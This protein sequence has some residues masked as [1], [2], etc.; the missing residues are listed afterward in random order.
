MKK[1][2]SR[3]IKES[4]SKPFF[5]EKRALDKDPSYPRISIITPSYNQAR[6]LESTI[7]SVLNQNYPN[8]EY[9]I[10]DG[11]ST[12]GSAD[13]IKKYEKYLAYW[14]SEPDKGQADALNKGFRMATGEIFGWL[15]SDD[16][17]YP[18]TI[19]V[20]VSFFAKNHDVGL[21]Y[22]ARHEIDNN[23]NF[24]RMVKAIPFNYNMFLYGGCYI[25][26]PSTF[27]RKKVWEKIG[28]FDIELHYAMDYD[29]WVRIAQKFKVMNLNIVLSEFRVHQDSKSQRLQ[30]IRDN[31]V[32]KIRERYIKR[33]FSNTLIKNF[34]MKFF[35]YYYRLIRKIIT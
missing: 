31:D 35:E 18:G 21:V 15:N 19:R 7:L 28:E 12:D 4:V 16:K 33:K 8:L 22:G 9:I 3:E 24:L 2:T 5:D 27:F 23:G 13:I 1:F 26:Q 29:Y 30:N 17:Y 20:I 14:V 34:Y 10:I 11:G 32:R 6:F 25:T